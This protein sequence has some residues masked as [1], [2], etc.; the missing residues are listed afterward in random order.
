MYLAFVLMFILSACGGTTV[1][2]PYTPPVLSIS[3]PNLE[4]ATGDKLTVAIIDDKGAIQSVPVVKTPEGRLIHDGDID[5]TRNAN[6]AKSRTL[7]GTQSVYLT[8]SQGWPVA[9]YPDGKKYYQIVTKLDPAS[10]M[11]KTGRWEQYQS[12][13]TTSFPQFKFVDFNSLTTK[14]TQYLIIEGGSGCS[15]EMG[16]WKNYTT[17]VWL[18]EAC[19]GYVGI[20]LHEIMHALGFAHE[21]TNTLCS[22]L[23]RINWENIDPFYVSNFKPLTDWGFDVTQGPCAPTSLMTY[24]PTSFTINGGDTLTSLTGVKIGQRNGF[25]D[26]DVVAV[27]QFYPVIAA[28][29]VVV[30]PPP[31]QKIGLVVSPVTV[32]GS[33]AEFK[34]TLNH[35]LVQP[36]LNCSVTILSNGVQVQSKVITS[37]SG[38]Q[39]FVVPQISTTQ[40]ITVSVSGIVGVELPLDY[41]FV[42]LAAEPVVVVPPPAPVSADSCTI[43]SPDMVAKVNVPYTHPWTV[44]LFTKSPRQVTITTPSGTARTLT[45][46]DTVLSAVYGGQMV[47]MA[48]NLPLKDFIIYGTGSKVGSFYDGQVVK[49]LGVDNIPV[50]CKGIRTITV[51]P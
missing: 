29:P 10:P 43:T 35:S 41:Q 36:T 26:S 44:T 8:G 25:S 18:S 9:A 38:D 16:G 6:F 39:S 3:A 17:S 20:P 37:C 15:A 4:V 32:V 28:D 22:S 7:L 27:N 30:V 33:N 2:A 21:H 24:G 11:A 45:E 42:V 13:I 48:N 23:I 51:Q 1:P 19:F 31:V 49:F 46:L 12:L 50:S 14:P 47:V 34:A 40:N 5:V